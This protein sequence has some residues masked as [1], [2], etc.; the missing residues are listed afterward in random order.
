M[1]SNEISER[2]VAAA[3]VQCGGAGGEAI[4]ALDPTQIRFRSL[5]GFRQQIITTS[6]A[7]ALPVLIL[8][9]DRTLSRRECAV[10]AF[11]H[12]TCGPF[13][14]SREPYPT[15]FGAVPNVPNVFCHPFLLEWMGP[16]LTAPTFFPFG[17]INGLIPVVPPLGS[18]LDLF[19]AIAVL[20]PT[21]DV[22]PFTGL[23]G[24][25]SVLV[26]KHPPMEGETTLLPLLPVPPP[27]P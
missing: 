11:R 17:I 22:D 12:A 7:L 18:N 9:L 10:L 16:D 25:F 4:N 26:M 21:I 2:L 14:G 5:V 20:L 23:A 6:D 15:L 27:G 13:A 8:P 3:W 24:D 1:A 19:D